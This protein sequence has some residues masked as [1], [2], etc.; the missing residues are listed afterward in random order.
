MGV[1]QF[2]LST[3]DVSAL[4][5][6]LLLVGFLFGCST[7]LVAVNVADIFGEKYIATNYGFIGV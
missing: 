4:S 1:V 7:A 5:V 3:G 6:C 2:I